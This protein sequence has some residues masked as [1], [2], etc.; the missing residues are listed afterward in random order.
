MRTDRSLGE[1]S[2]ISYESVDV[3]MNINAAST[4]KH[5][6][7]ADDEQIKYLVTEVGES[8]AVDSH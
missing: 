2:A 3:A 4:A 8:T 7:R 5:I 6:R 1:F